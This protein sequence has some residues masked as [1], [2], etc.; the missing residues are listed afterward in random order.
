[1]R[2]RANSAGSLL[3]EV[4]PPIPSPAAASFPLAKTSCVL[5]QSST[6]PSD[7]RHPIPSDPDTHSVVVVAPYVLTDTTASSTV[8]GWCRDVTVTHS[9]GFALLIV[10]TAPSGTFMRI[11]RY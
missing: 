6:G 10:A 7:V 3:A 11:V 5:T 2:S 8:D 1:M 9:P 4:I